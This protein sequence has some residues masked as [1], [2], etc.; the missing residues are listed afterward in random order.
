MTTSPLLMIPISRWLLADKTT[1]RGITGTIVA[2]AGVA[3][4]LMYA[5]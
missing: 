4:P 1:I 2:M 5:W 3:I